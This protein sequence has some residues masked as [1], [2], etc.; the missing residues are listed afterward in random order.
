MGSRLYGALTAAVRWRCAV[1]SPRVELNLEGWPSTATAAE[2]ARSPHRCRGT[3]GTAP[4]P[5]RGERMEARKGIHKRTRV[6]T[7]LL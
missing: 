7:R 2:A 3:L 6:A 4:E 5:R 1:A